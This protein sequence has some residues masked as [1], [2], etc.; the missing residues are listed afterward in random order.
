MYTPCKQ[1]FD[2]A[3]MKARQ[4]DTLVSRL[5]LGRLSNCA[6]VTRDC[7][8]RSECQNMTCRINEAV[9]AA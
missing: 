3:S 7:P 8:Y 5:L 9:N 2:T 4:G 1:M 6:S